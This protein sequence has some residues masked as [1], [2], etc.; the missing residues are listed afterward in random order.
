[1]AAVVFSGWPKALRR[2]Y[3]SPAGPKPLPG[4]PTTWHSESSLSKKSQEDRPFGVRS[5]H[6][7]G[8]G[9]AGDGRPV[10][11]ELTGFATVGS[12]P[13]Q[14]EEG[15]QEPVDPDDVG[16]PRTDLV[17]HERDDPEPQRQERAQ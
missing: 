17:R 11:R 1:M 6:E 14:G 12:R 3:P 4:V 9:E 7:D 13:A 16:D 2:K 10:G 5:Q 8:S 15:T